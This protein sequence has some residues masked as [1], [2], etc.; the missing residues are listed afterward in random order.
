MTLPLK[1]WRLRRFNVFMMKLLLKNT[2][3]ITI[4]F[5]ASEELSTGLQENCFQV[6]NTS[7]L[8]GWPELY[9]HILRT[10]NIFM[11]KLVQSWLSYILI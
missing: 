2:C 10:Y 5:T 1:L 3:G 7:Q 4:V 11:M 8:Q 9:E 6:S